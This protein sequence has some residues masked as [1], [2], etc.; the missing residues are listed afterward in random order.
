MGWFGLAALDVNF[1]GIGTV[2]STIA[3]MVSI[4][5]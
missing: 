4:T 2:I 3:R 5:Q 1:S